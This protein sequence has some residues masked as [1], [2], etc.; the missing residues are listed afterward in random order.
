MIPL[1][2][3][4]ETVALRFDLTNNALRRQSSENA[5]LARSV[6]CYLARGLQAGTPRAIGEAVMMSEED[7]EAA[8]DWAAG[9]LSDSREFVQRIAEIEIEAR[10]FV[11]VA[12]KYGLPLPTTANPKAIALRLIH[13]PREAGRVSIGDLCAIGAAYLTLDRMR[14]GASDLAQ[15]VEAYERAQLAAV[16]LR[17]THS[18]RGAI[19]RRDAARATILKL[20]GEKHV[21]NAL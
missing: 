19:Q 7:V 15:A 3:I 10:A 2:V 1:D 6:Y 21:E 14:P 5:R 16:S 4:L 11:G 13:S 20:L 12:A 9:E 17:F 8:C 18:E